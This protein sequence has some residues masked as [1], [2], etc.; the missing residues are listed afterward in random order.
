M[1]FGTMRITANPDRQLAIRVLRRAAEL[2]V[3]HF[4]TASFYVSPGGTLG[5]GSGPRR[6][7]AELLRAALHPYPDGC[8]IASKVISTAPLRERVESTLRLLGVDTLDVVNLRLRDR[9]AEVSLEQPFSE[10]AALRER[11]LIRH[12]GI[13]NVHRHHLQQA[14]AI[15]PVVGVQNAYGLEL[16]HPGDTELLAECGRRGIA[17]VPFF[18]VAG[19]GHERGAVPL[20]AGPVAQRHGVSEHQVR[21]AWTLHQGA[22]VLAIPGTGSVAHLEQNMAAARLRLTAA[23]LAQLQAD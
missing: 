23:D 20:A 2:G 10:L 17:F 5:V 7:A 19:R 9:D 11:G 18:S 21:L 13:S 6:W 15:A 14:Q 4:D 22:H 12:L 8:V 1:G 16:R 3:D